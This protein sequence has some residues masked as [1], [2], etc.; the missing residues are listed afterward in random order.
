[1]PRNY[2]VISH[3]HCD[4]EWYMTLENFRIKLVELIDNLL[5]VL[6]EWP[7]YRFHLDAQT[8]VL[9]DYLEIRPENR[10]KLEQYIK[11]GRILVGPWYVQNDFYLTSGE[12]TVRNLLTG[13]R[14]AEEFGKC[15]LVGYAPDQ[16]GIISQLPQI[17]NRFGI[18][19]CLF[20]R[21]Y[22]S[23]PNKKA[24]L[25]WECEDGS[26]VLAVYMP[27]WYNNA[28]RFP[29]DPDLAYRL[30]KSIDRNLQTTSSTNNFLLMNGVDHLEAQEDLLPILDELND[31]LT[32][33]SRVFQ[34]T[35]PEYFERLKR[36]VGDIDCY[37]GEMR[38]GGKHNI[39]AGTL[40]SRVYLKQWNNKCQML[41]EKRLEPVYVWLQ[42]LGLREYPKGYMSYLW[43]L[44]MENHAHDSICG[45]SLDRVHQHMVDR[46]KRVEECATDLLERGIE[47]ISSYITR[48]GKNSGQYLLT[49][50]NT[51]MEER[52][53]VIE[54]EIE[55]LEEED[56]KAFVIF[57]PQG[58]EIP[59]EVLDK[60]ERVKGV[61]SPI[62]LP[63]VINVKTWRV[64]LWISGLK[65]LSYRTYTIEPKKGSGEMPSVNCSGENEPGSRVSVFPCL[66]ENEYI[67][68]EIMENGT[69]SLLEK[70]SGRYYK[71][72]FVIEDM[73]DT[74]D[75]Y[76]YND[77]PASVPILSTAFDA[78]VECVENH[79][80][81]QAY[82]ISFTMRVPE[83]YCFDKDER[84]TG[85]CDLPVG[86]LLSLDRGSRQ[87]DAVISVDNRARDHR[88][89]VLFPTYIDSDLSYA[90]IPFDV[91]VRDRDMIR[92][93]RTEVAQQPNTAFV[94][95]CDEDCGLAIFNEGLN[96][97][98]H[99][100]DQ[101]NTIA[102]TL[103]RGN[104]YISRDSSGLPV[105]ERWLVPENQCLGKHSFRLALY[106]YSGTLGEARVPQTADSF[107]N[108]LFSFYQPVDKRKFTGGRPFVQGSGTA[109]LF[110]RENRYPDVSLPE[111][112]QLL[113]GGGRDIV[114]SC[115]KI[116]E[117]GHS[118]ILRVYNSSSEA[119]TFSIGSE[120][121]IKEAYLVNL[122]EDRL[123]PLVVCDNAVKDIPLKAKEILTVELILN[124]LPGIE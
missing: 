24:E 12:A 113:A 66:L 106:P 77:N 89:R 67:R 85:L 39:L 103:L 97:Y 30:L 76:V 2:C 61:T 99:M 18:D 108:P 3:T 119:R 58:C 37:K 88:L 49:V 120:L 80:L 123:S 72:L 1:M 84:S 59:F 93:K 20:A 52:S 57:D 64:K 43:K 73:E 68:A 55:F 63:G 23:T 78:A 33:G 70:E 121:G 54:A 56:P 22:G 10:E 114:Y 82:R 102:L 94:S 91:A 115:L 6:E 74:G 112:Q 4:R 46:F 47:E 40:S 48:K 9:E 41:L 124:R 42:T 90:G 69:V 100:L 87:L 38:I 95:V 75:S 19:T 92:S 86:I 31:R 34:D 5:D 32:D 45:C 107:N 71:N 11:E 110:F 28:Q 116:K 26:R 109:G 29:A 25:Y 62:N 51:A 83:E 53:G 16:F 111:E 15:T 79:S 60:F 98:E 117:K 105:E 17:Y 65:G 101:D 35:M 81:T 8:I 44:L 27:F 7:D 50:F 14:I 21:G 118:I 104:G 13:I 96:E 122:R 36:D